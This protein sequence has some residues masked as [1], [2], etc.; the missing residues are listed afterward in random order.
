MDSKKGFNFEEAK[1]IGEQLGIKWD[2]FEVEEFRQGLDVELEHGLRDQATN[3]TSDEPLTTGKIALA[4]LNEFPDYYTRLKK[5]ENE[6]QIPT[7]SGQA[8]IKKKSHLWR[9]ILIAFVVVGIGALSFAA[10]KNPLQVSLCACASPPFLPLALPFSSRQAIQTSWRHP[11][12]G[13]CHSQASTRG[14]PA[15]ACHRRLSLSCKQDYAS[16]P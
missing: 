11:R 12:G 15:C 10:Y 9:N 1:E 16:A 8:E 4:H 3:V 2:K 5:M 7:L 14:S 6:N 13:T